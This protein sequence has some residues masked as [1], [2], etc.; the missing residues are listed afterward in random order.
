MSHCTKAKGLA[1]TTT[2][3]SCYPF[4]E[5]CLPMYCSELARLQPLLT[6]RRRPQQSGFT[7]GR[8]TIDAILALRLLSELQQEFYQPLNVAYIDIKAA[9]DS[10]DRAT[11]WKALRS[12]GAPPFLIQLIKQLHTGTTSRVRVGGQLSEPFETTS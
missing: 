3:S 5:K 2:R 10:V 12:S 11:I 1:T 6:A 9:F 4:P 8:F 7:P